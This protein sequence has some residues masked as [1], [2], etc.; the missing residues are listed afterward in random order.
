MARLEDY[1]DDVKFV[2]VSSVYKTEP[3]GLKDQPWFYN[4]VAHYRIDPEIWA[5]EGLLSSLS[6]VENQ[7]FRERNVP[8]GPRV[9]D[10]DMLLFGDLVQTT[11]YLD[12]PH[13]RMLER[14]FVLVPLAEIAPDLIFPNGTSIQKAL[15]AIEYRQEGNTI[16]QD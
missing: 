1:G 6:A 10:V 8:E 3:L 13:P 5:P 12:L 16:W 7:M 11:G 14:A 15:S 4:Q 2:N 9:I